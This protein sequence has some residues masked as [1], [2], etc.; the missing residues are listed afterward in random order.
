MSLH[1]T[2]V[3]IYKIINNVFDNVMY[4]IYKKDLVMMFE[5]HPDVPEYGYFDG[6]KLQQIML[7]LLSNAVK[8]TDQG[9]ITLAVNMLG[10]V[11]EKCHLQVVISDTGIGISERNQKKL[12]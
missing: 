4:Q 6:N 2:K 12:I 1:Y 10:I 11:D 7:N 3:S 5:I 8:F 9:T